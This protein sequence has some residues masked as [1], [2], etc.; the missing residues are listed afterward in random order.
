MNAI[1]DRESI[2]E[3]LR[4]D[5]TLKSSLG[6]RS[7]FT[8]VKRF[9]IVWAIWTVMLLVT[10]LPEALEWNLV[11]LLVTAMIGAFCLSYDLFQNRRRELQLA[12]RIYNLLENTPVLEVKQDQ[13]KRLAHITHPKFT[14]DCQLD[15]AL[16]L[17]E[18]IA[19][20]KETKEILDRI[21]SD[22]VQGS[23]QNVPP[24]LEQ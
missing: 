17:A 23:M 24:R 14:A 12:E 15:T 1:L 13:E 4:N 22:Q 7:Q 16:L 6:I 5:R 10:P 11:S 18:M 20:E 19:S 3:A 9:L 8:A 2:T 21:P